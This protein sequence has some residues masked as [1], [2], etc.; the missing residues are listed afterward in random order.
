M[1]TDSSCPQGGGS[2]N[3]CPTDFKALQPLESSGKICLPLSSIAPKGSERASWEGASQV[4]DTQIELEI[5]RQEIEAARAAYQELQKK[6]EAEG[7]LPGQIRDL[8]GEDS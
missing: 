4:K 5:T 3:A 1:C 8:M 7:L 6:T 2:E